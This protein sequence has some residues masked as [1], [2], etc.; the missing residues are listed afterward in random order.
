[1][2]GGSWGSGKREAGSGELGAGE[3]GAPKKAYGLGLTT[4]GIGFGEETEP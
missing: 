4:Q 3:L 2:S 1:L